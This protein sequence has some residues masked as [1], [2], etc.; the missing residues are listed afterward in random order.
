MLTNY[1]ISYILV[2]MWT[3]EDKK[4]IFIINN[5]IFSPK[6]ICG[7]RPI[8]GSRIGLV[9]RP[10]LKSLFETNKNSPVQL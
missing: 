10:V 6:S 7:T 5:N 8:I 9:A 1:T 4:H 2:G 3:D